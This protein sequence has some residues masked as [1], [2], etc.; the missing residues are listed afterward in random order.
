MQGQPAETKYTAEETHELCNQDTEQEIVIS[1][2]DNENSLETMPAEFMF[3]VFMVPI[4][5]EL[6][7]FVSGIKMGKGGK[8]SKTLLQKRNVLKDNNMILEIADAALDRY[9]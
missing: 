9:F 1:G 7:T 8:R 3:D 2:S 4:D 6:L 5:P